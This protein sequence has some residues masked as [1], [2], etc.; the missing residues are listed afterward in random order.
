MTVMP[1]SV[2]LALP[3]EWDD[4][5]MDT[6][7]YKSYLDSQIERLRDAGITS[8]SDLR[9]FELLAF[10]LHKSAQEEGVIFSSSFVAIEEPDSGTTTEED[11]EPEYLLIMAAVV[12]STLRRADL[13][14][15]I[16]LMAEAMVMGFSDRAPS[17]DAN[18][19]FDE[20]E[21]PRV[22][23]VGEHDAARLARLM[24][25]EGKPG[26]V[27]RQFTQTYLVSVANGDATIVLQFSTINFDY[28]R[29]F[30]ELFDHIAGT[31]RVLY[32]DDETFIDDDIDTRSADR[33]R[34][35]A[36]G[37]GEERTGEL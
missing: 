16:P 31:L 26:E 9:Q 13:G 25:I 12:V 23:K 4:I 18:A 1:D 11:T 20:I 37:G 19:R 17:D 33:D 21:P 7:E 34:Q 22:C 24:T 35:E 36:G 8:R 5:P 10:L 15:D 32:P 30:S 29:Q 3:A 28:A 27:F 6:S 2:A 14:T